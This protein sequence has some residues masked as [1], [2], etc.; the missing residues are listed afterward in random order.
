MMPKP[1]SL[2]DTRV[3]YRGDNLNQ[4]RKLPAPLSETSE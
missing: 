1:S 3:I 4:L 2:I